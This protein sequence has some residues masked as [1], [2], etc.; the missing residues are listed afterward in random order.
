MHSVESPLII[1]FIVSALQLL[2]INCHVLDGN[3]V[4]QLTD[5]P[6]EEPS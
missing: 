3:I 6:S 2:I 1:E 4:V 5:V